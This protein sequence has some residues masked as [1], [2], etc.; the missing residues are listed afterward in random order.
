MALNSAQLIGTGLLD[1]FRNRIIN[2]SMRIDQRNVL[3]ASTLNADNQY[4]VDRFRTGTSGGSWGTGVI[5]GQ[6]RNGIITAAS[7]YEAGASPGAQVCNSSLK[8]TVTT[9]DASLA[10]TDGYTIAQTLE[11]GSVSDFAFGTANAQT[12]TLSFWVKSSITGTYC[13]SLF[14]TGANRSYV[15]TYTISAANT[16]EYKTITIPGDTSG[17]WFQTEPA[18]NVRWDLGSGS[19]RNAASANTWSAGD[20]SRVSGSVNWISTLNATFYVTAVQLEKG[21]VATEFEF[22]SFAQELALCLRYYQRNILVAT[23]GGATPT[24]ANRSFYAMVNW[25]VA[26]RV[27]P[28]M[29]LISTLTNLNMNAGSWT[30]LDPSRGRFSATSILANDA[31]IEAQYEASA[32]L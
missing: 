24:V 27:T 8:L 20:F 26:F 6:Q 14:G 4:P 7:N 23:G 9:A 16:W 2:G 18:L 31:Y 32:E 5:S 3:A 13:A 29:T 25:P 28:T 19:G 17:T 11:I 10:S 15:A 22:R 1:G 12:V 30:N 21:S